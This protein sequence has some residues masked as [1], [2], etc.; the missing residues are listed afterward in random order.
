MQVVVLLF[1]CWPIL[2][3]AEWATN[4]I[5]IALWYSMMFLLC[6]DRTNNRSSDLLKDLHWEIETAMSDFCSCIIFFVQ[7][8]LPSVYVN[9]TLQI[10]KPLKLHKCYLVCYVA[11]IILFCCSTL[12]SYELYKISNHS[13]WC[14]QFSSHPWAFE[15]Q[16]QT[17]L[18]H[19]QQLILIAKA[20]L[21]CPCFLCINVCVLWDAEPKTYDVLCMWYH[22]SSALLF[23]LSPKQWFWNFG[24]RGHFSWVDKFCMSCGLNWSFW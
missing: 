2:Q 4:V 15:F 22:A 19:D 17:Y 1:T 3:Y 20:G 16:V 21:R 8:L 14:V 12:H 18:P 11:S 9:V 24:S 13:F 23:I 5:F 6:F 7:C 10:L